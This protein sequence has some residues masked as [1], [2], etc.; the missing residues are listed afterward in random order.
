MRRTGE[1]KRNKRA[2]L[3]IRHM[4]KRHFELNCL[5]Q[6][7]AMKRNHLMLLKSERLL[8]TALTRRLTKLNLLN[9]RLIA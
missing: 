9:S 1:N 5:R 8:V 3:L 4:K 7:K 2:V 6:W